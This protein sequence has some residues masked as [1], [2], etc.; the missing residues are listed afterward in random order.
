MF[1]LQEPWREA[2]NQ[3]ELRKATKALEDSRK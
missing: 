3:I 2:V 1:Y